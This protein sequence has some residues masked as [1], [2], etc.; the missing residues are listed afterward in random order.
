V[1]WKKLKRRTR[2]RKS[3]KVNPLPLRVLDLKLR[4]PSKIRLV[5]GASVEPADYATLSYTWGPRVPFM[6]TD[7]T[8][9]QCRHGISITTL[10]KAF[11]HAVWVTR[12]LAIRYLWIDALCIG[13]NNEQEWASQSAQ[14]GSIFAYSTLTIAASDA[15]HCREGFLCVREPLAY[16]SCL[17][18]P[19]LGHRLE[20]TIG[21][22]AAAIADSVLDCR[23]W[24]FQERLLAQRTVHFAQNRVRW[25]CYH[26][27][28]C[29]VHD[30]DH[31][32]CDCN[33]DPT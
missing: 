1:L 33:R 20:V 23:G 24:V 6:L 28:K 2:A 10:P 3:R 21:C 5:E 12:K 19:D 29:E 27:Y 7:E 15:S 25:E 16:N 30:Q 17:L 11:Q 4:D 31:R 22:S 32:S 18:P 14:M 26:G 13:Q 8:M 9:E